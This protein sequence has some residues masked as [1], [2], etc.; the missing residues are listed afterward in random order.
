VSPDIKGANI[1]EPNDILICVRNGSKALIGKSAL[2]PEGMP[3]CT[4]G[5]FMTVFRADAPHFVFQLMQ[6][7]AFQKQVAADLGATIN[8]I[9]GG[10]LVKYRFI[11]PEPDEQNRIAECLW[12]LGSRIAAESGKL[13]ALK[14]HKNSLMQ[15]LFPSLAAD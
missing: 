4:H 2:I 8:S 15:Q 5:A 12:S 7:A 3:L 6:S 14:D 1:S 9:N 11:V 13:H 10:Q